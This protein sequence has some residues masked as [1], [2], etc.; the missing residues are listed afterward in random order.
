M[1]GHIYPNEKSPLN[2]S[3]TQTTQTTPG[4]VSRLE[5]GQA[6]SG[7]MGGGFPPEAELIPK[8]RERKPWKF[9]DL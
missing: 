8:K 7:G 4:R 2:P 3:P 1:L 5:G 9:G 6:E